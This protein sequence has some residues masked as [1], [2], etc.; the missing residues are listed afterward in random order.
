MRATGAR[1]T[2]TAAAG[3]PPLTPLQTAT[4]ATDT[5]L[6]SAFD[7]DEKC[8]GPDPACPLL[9]VPVPVTTR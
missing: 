6:M 1:G 4:L 2:A 8:N 9:K 3:R 5:R 7:A